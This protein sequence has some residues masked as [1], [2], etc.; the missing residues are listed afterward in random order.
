MMATADRERL[1]FKVQA[2]VYSSGLFANSLSSMMNI[3]VPLWVIALDSSPL[4]IGLVIGARSFLPLLLSIHGGVMMDSIGTRRVILFFSIIA[5]ITAPL[6]PALPW[7]PALIVLQM[8]NGLAAS[9][10]WIGAQTMIGQVMG[11]S[12]RHAGRLS[13]ISR[14]GS[15]VAPIAVGLIWDL[16]GPWPTFLF[17]A[18][19]GIAMWATAKFLP[20]QTIK[21][22]AQKPEKPARIPLRDL[23]PKFSDYVN[24]FRMLAVPAIAFVVMIALIRIS[25][26]GIKSSFYVVYLNEI[27]LTGTLIGLLSSANSFFGGFGALSVRPLTRIFNAPVLLFT[28][29]VLSIAIISVTPLLGSFFLLMVFACLRGTTMGMSQPL[30]ISIMSKSSGEAKQGQAVGLRTTMNRLATVITPIFMGGIMEVAGIEMSF[31]ITGAILT[32]LCLAPLWGMI[33]AGLH[34]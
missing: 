14:M 18:I 32:L 31:Y 30:M 16:L 29:V 5:M 25:G 1:P 33:K 17:L 7:I 19:P 4:T 8:L 9:M 34:R 27:G 15:V 23:L 12:T 2:A 28:T 26:N 22:D 6:Y 24:A 20:E 11:G 3:A 21:Q 13:F 10:G